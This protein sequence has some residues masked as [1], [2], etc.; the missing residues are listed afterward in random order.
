MIV[1]FLLKKEK[2]C[3]LCLSLKTIAVLKLNLNNTAY[4]T[5][6]AFCCHY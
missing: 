4:K 3:F 1:L 6:N 5:E 2:K